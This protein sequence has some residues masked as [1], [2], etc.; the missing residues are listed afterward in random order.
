MGGPA[1]FDATRLQISQHLGVE[2]SFDVAIE[3]ERR[4]GFLYQ[5]MVATGRHALVLGVSGGVDSATTGRLCHLAVRRL[6][7]A[8]RDATFVA[9]RLPYGSQID[10]ADAQLALEFVGAD[11]VM[12][13]DVRPATDG[14]I[15]ALRAGGLTFTDDRQR[16]FVYGNIKARQRM[17][18]QYAI[19]GALPGLVVGTDH[20][21][22]AV[23]GFFTKHGDGAADLTPL[24]GLTKRRVR[25]LAKALG[26]PAALIAKAPTADLEDLTPGRPDEEA[27]GVTYDDIDDF[28]EGRPVHAAAARRI[29]HHYRA[30]EHKRR[31]P[32]TPTDEENR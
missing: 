2:P 20:A 31:L 1:T 30:T 32:I 9:V 12:T 19:A 7:A 8:G 27:L 10:E 28:L 11:R 29:L 4:V 24:T 15:E 5:Q 22:E 21:A 25:A 3:I 18:V 16:D 26:A 13:V 23:T 6:R 17:V 14:A